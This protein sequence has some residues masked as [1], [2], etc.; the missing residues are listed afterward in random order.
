MLTLAVSPRHIVVGPPLSNSPEGKVETVYRSQEGVADIVTTH[1][2]A[3]T[4]ATRYTGLEAMLRE[5]RLALLSEVQ[6][7]KRDARTDNVKELAVLDDGESSEAD[8]QDEIGFALLEIKEETLKKITTALQRLRNGTYGSCM[9]CGS[10]IHEARLRA[11]PFAV[12]CKTC[13]EACELDERR[14]RMVAQRRQFAATTF[15]MSG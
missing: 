6:N 13:E 11:L 2:R 1:P 7:R 9:E 14:E 5:R 3:R 4:R 10:N 15:D 12:R 8:I